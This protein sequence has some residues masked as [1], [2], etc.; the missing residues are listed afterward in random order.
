MAL[1]ESGRP[2]K[3]HS[4]SIVSSSKLQNYHF[5]V[6]R[7]VSP[8]LIFGTTHLRTPGGIG[9]PMKSRAAEAVGI[10]SE[11]WA[12]SQAAFVGQK[13]FIRTSSWESHL[14]DE[15]VL[16]PKTVWTTLNMF[17]QLSSIGIY[18][19]VWK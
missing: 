13:Q 12:A 11:P 18:G 1:S 14:D 10:G 2:L 4:W 8:I 7:I 19:F 15:S 16:A 17:E 3:F 9:V 5:G 6:S